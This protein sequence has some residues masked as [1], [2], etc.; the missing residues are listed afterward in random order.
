MNDLL[1]TMLEEIASNE[2]SNGGNSFELSQNELQEWKSIP[3]EQKE[4]FITEV[5]K[6]GYTKFEV[7]EEGEVTYCN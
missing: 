4:N 3:E 1:K 7:N 5:H 6:L 2:I